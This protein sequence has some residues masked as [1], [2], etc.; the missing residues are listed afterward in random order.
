MAVL[1]RPRLST[2]LYTVSIVAWALC[3]FAAYVRLI[4]WALATLLALP[5]SLALGHL[6][7]IKRRDQLEETRRRHDV[8][9]QAK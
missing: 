8:G 6:A 9:T 2:I 4:P 1:R 5:V 3:G 7:W